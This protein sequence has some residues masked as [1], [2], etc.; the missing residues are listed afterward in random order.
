MRTPEGVVKDRIRQHLRQMGAYC[1]SP[2]QMGLGVSTVDLLCCVHGKFLAVEVKREGKKPTPRQYAVLE[3]IEKAGGI[4]FWC[5]SY[6]GFLDNM[7]LHGL[8][9][10]R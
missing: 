8:L 7:F 3:E 4:S 6:E 2:V 5:D 9:F 10:R 1:F